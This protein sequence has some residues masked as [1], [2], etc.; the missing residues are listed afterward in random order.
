MAEMTPEQEALYALNWNVPRSE[1]PMA[2]QLEYDRLRPAW[3]QGEA[4]PAAGQPEAARLAWERRHPPEAHEPPDPRPVARRAMTSEVKPSVITIPSMRGRE[5]TI[6]LTGFCVVAAAV[7]PFAQPTPQW[8]RHAPI[9]AVYLAVVAA[10]AALPLCWGWRTGVRFD[11]HGLTI[12]Y[13][14]GIRRIGW[15]EVSRFADGRT[16]GLGEGA[17]QVWTL[18][19]VRRNGRVLKVKATAR[20][21]SS[22][23]PKVLTAILLAAERY[24]IPAA[25]TGVASKR[26][27]RPSVEENPSDGP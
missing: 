2:A 22:A 13:F 14:F 3:E 5:R 8:A 7:V 15:H 20:D 12:R 25:L 11:D 16:A 23:E 27:S 18:E 1:L 19:V 10:V 9:V 4:R 24:G 26:R 17:G 6:W 21:G